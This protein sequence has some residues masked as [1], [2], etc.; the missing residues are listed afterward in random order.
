MSISSS[1][2]RIARVI[3]PTVNRALESV[4]R[5]RMG[6]LV[7]RVPLLRAVL[8][9]FYEA[10]GPTRA[11]DLSREVIDESMIG[12]PF[13]WQSRILGKPLRMPID[14][15][16]A[17]GSWHSAL[18]WSS[19]GHA[20][21]R[22]YYEYALQRAKPRVFFDVGANYGTHSYP[23]ALHGVRC[24]CF[25]PQSRCTAFIR[26]VATLND[27]ANLIEIEP[28]ALDATDGGTAQLFTSESTWVSSL[29]REMTERFEA[30]QPI[31]VPRRTLDGIVADKGVMPDLLKIDVEGWE[32][33]V[34]AGAI[35][36]IRAARPTVLIEVLHVSDSAPTIYHTFDQ[37]GYR[38]VALE[39]RGPRLISSLQELVSAPTENF[40]LF[41]SADQAHAFVNAPS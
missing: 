41:Q 4:R 24:L 2:T 7:L 29:I 12:P 5:R 28:V 23:L 33:P 38:T 10:F 9:E 30:A 27:L 17:R 34:V 15:R 36:T 26:R 22:R 16:M 39:P 32:A 31:E 18:N 37:L 13:V 25:E 1:R 6:A 14:P 11:G 20:P 21:L 35:N 40:A 19:S 8:N 3:R